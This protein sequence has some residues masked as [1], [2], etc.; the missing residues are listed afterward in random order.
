[1]K[2]ETHQQ[3]TALVGTTIDAFNLMAEKNYQ[4]DYDKI[5]WWVSYENLNKWLVNIKFADGVKETEKWEAEEYTYD[6]Q[7][8]YVHQGADSHKVIKDLVDIFETIAERIII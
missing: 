1:M 8:L 5:E 3:L 2:I 6:S 7:G 4:L